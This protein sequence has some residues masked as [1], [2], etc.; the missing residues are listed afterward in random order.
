MNTP[1]FIF[2]SLTLGVILSSISFSVIAQDDNVRNDSMF[3]SYEK[4]PEFPGGMDGMA[5]YFNK[6]L[7]YPKSAKSDK[8]EGTVYVQFT[9]G[10]NGELKNIQVLR[11]IHE[12]LDATA[13]KLIENMP[14]WTPGTHDGE[15]VEI[16][17][18]LPIKFS[19]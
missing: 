11:G 2:L 3:V 8:V 12:D 5:Q 7:K 10:K 13:V 19:L 14:N 15:P 1:H 6:N 18:N 4:M 9:V 16:S 17:F